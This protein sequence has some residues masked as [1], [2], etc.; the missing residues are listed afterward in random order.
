MLKSLHV[1]KPVFPK[2]FGSTIS[3][4]VARRIGDIIEGEGGNRDLLQHYR[5]VSSMLVNNRRFETMLRA[6]VTCK[7][8]V[9]RLYHWMCGMRETINK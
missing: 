2:L 6:S 5:G 8:P 7:G 1:L 4:P 9:T 3:E